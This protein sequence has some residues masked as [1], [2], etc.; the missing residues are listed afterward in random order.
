[1]TIGSRRHQ[2]GNLFLLIVILL[3]AFYLRVHRLGTQSLWGDEGASLVMAQRSPGQIILHAT[4]DIH[5]PLYYLLL[6]WWSIP[7]GLSEFS[8]RFLS[9]ALGVAL[10]A[11]I[12]PLGRRLLSSEVALVA[13]FLAA[14]SPLLVYYSQEARMYMLMAAL[15]TLSIY[16]YW[17]LMTSWVKKEASLS[18]VEEGKILIAYIGVTAGALYTQYF[19]FTIPLLQNILF[20]LTFWQVW[21]H[22]PL[23]LK[24]GGSQVVIALLYVPWL[25]RVVGK[26]GMWPAVSQPFS[27]STLFQRVFQV[28]TYGLS[29]REA[30][31]IIA[32]ITLLV[33][34]L[35]SL[36]LVVRRPQVWRAWLRPWPLIFLALYFLVPLMVIYFLSLR[37]PMYNP[38]FLL[39]ATPPYYLLIGLAIAIISKG[40]GFWI[41]ESLRRWVWSWGGQA[42]F[43]TLVLGII[44]H[45]SYRSLKAYYDN[46]RY[47]RDDYR[48]LATY[49][50]RFSRPQDAI[51]LSAPGQEEV[52]TYYYQGSLPLYPLPRSNPIDVAATEAELQS[53]ARQYGRL[54][55]VRWGD[56]EADPSRFISRWLDENAYETTGRW[57]GN[58]E[59]LAYSLPT[60]TTTPTTPLEVNFG[61]Q[62][63]LLGYSLEGGDQLQPAQPGD[64]L[65]LTLYW[66]ALAPLIRNYAVFTH[67]IDQN[68]YV[69]GQHD[70]EPVGWTRPTTTWQPGEV[71]ADRHGISV[72]YGTPPGEYRIEL[73]LYELNGQRLL[74]Y[75]TGDDR[76]LLRTGVKVE[77]G[78]LMA[79]D[80]ITP[81]NSAN[82]TFDQVRL[83]GFDLTRLGSDAPTTSFVQGDLALLTL[84]W[85]AREQPGADYIVNLKLRSG[86]GSPALL[87]ANPPAEG[88]YPTRRWDKGEV[89]RDL[90][91][92]VLNT[93]PGRYDL[94]LGLSQN[95]NFIVP[96]GKRGTAEGWAQLGT[97]TVQEVH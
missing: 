65:Q 91:L 46:P 6:H 33:V 18:Q 52:F 44:S 21:R 14:I 80:I 56:Q 72:S 79:L 88:N 24:W 15:S 53:M 41:K 26:I 5:P 25:V 43:I 68:Q 13:A 19:A 61:N 82:L 50:Q 64:V 76:I 9:L 97:I 78:P 70:G 17:R 2:I 96:S 7:T 40:I 93:P 58:V 37:R 57:F 95:D 22:R 38:K 74:I 29:W 31:L 8:L 23:W 30:P 85:Y 59:L 12:Y 51:L 67:L 81:Q 34:V 32:G 69:L 1:M 83:V 86:S 4:S 66:R 54:W 75:G 35:I 60:T 3:I 63:Q 28:F 45:G 42:V 94:L 84:Y 71:V 11:L 89:V 10:V 36:W 92:L 39:L 77:K 20:L 62:I 48:G 47:A 16:L 90:H 49:I 87:K 73:G 55:F 27:L